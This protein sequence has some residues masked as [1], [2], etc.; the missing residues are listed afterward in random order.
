MIENTFN[1]NN[2]HNKV[3]SMR[4][5]DETIYRYMFCD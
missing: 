4:V 3:E 1:N 2:R 5:N